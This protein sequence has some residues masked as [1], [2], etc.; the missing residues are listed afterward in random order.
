MSADWSLG[1]GLSR[2]VPGRPLIVVDADEVLLRFVD[3]F[4]RYLRERGLFLD[5]VSYRLHGNVRRRDDHRA[6]LDVEV[7]ALLDEFRAELDWLDPVEGA[8]EVLE[9]LGRRAG[10]VV[11]SNIAPAQAPARS[12]NLARLGFAF[13][14]IANSG[15]KG[16]ALKQLANRAGARTFFIDDI[17]QHH[18]S[19][20]EHAPD[21]VR[22]HLIGDDRLKPLLP[23]CPEAQYAKDWRA[24]GALIEGYL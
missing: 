7:T 1:H 16:P 6:V 10:V 13:P 17:P 12:R 23:P 22:I 3:G 18:Q 19:C 5:L 4:D 2:I 8:A 9:S 20:A 14:L 24:A 15:P 11:L 21:I